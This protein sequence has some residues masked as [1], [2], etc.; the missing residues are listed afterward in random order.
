MQITK[1]CAIC[2]CKQNYNSK[3][4]VAKFAK[5]TSLE[6]KYFF[7]LWHKPA[8]VCSICG[9]GSFDISVCKN[10]GILKDEQFLSVSKNGVLNKI[11][12]F[13]HTKLGDYLKC[14]AYYNLIGDNLNEGV[15]YLLA[16]E[17]V[18]LAIIHYM[19]DIC[20]DVVGGEPDKVEKKLT[21]YA[22]ML[23]DYGLGR[24]E[25]IYDQ[26]KYNPDLN[27]L[28]GG[29]LITGKEDQLEFGKSVLSK[30][31]KMQL[32]PIQK[33]TCEFLLNKANSTNLKFDK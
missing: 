2:G 4:S 20:E 1:Q 29:L 6:E 33:K 18:N 28:F 3:Y 24:L 10:L 7:E 5:P 32:K 15:S 17:E 13:M 14:G 12:E 11:E 26:N 19:R 23:F 25:L 31:L 27:I 8:L 9:Y 22:D 30:T 21:K 16:S